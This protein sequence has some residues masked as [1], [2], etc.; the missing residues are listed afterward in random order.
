MVPVLGRTS[1]LD[2]LLDGGVVLSMVGV[3]ISGIEGKP[4]FILAKAVGEHGERGSG[5]MVSLE[6]R[7]ERKSTFVGLPLS[8]PALCA[9]HASPVAVETKHLPQHDMKP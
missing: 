8:R 5:Y 9:E 3:A 7:D 6:A 4:R 1:R 2:E